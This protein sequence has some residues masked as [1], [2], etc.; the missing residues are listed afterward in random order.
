M[1]SCGPSARRGPPID[2]RSG[3][4][5]C[6]ER[7]LW[8]MDMAGS[9]G[10]KR[11]L[12]GALCV[13][14]VVLSACAVPGP[15]S[16]LMRPADPVVIT[17]G[18]VPAL[19][20]SA[21]GDIV[22]F[23]YLPGAGWGQ[24]PV[25]VDERK[26]VNL[27]TTYNQPAN[28]V[29]IV[30]YADPD[31]FAGADP[32]PMLDADDEIAFMAR[33]TGGRPPSYSVPAGVV[34]GTGVQVLVADP[35][36]RQG[37]SPLLKTG[38]AYLFR[39]SGTLDPAAGRDYVDY[40]FQL[41]SG[42]YKTTY[43]LADGPNPEDS[44]ITTSHYQHH[45][46]DR[47]MSDSI[48]VT[49]P[50]ASGADILDRHK[51][52]FAPG[53]CGRSEDT[54]NDAEGAFI[55]NTNG[56]VRA[57]RSYIGANSGPNTQRDHIFYDQR[58]DI[59]TFL[60]VHAISGVMDFLDYSPD[61]T[62]MT[63]SNDKNPAGVTIDGNPESV[64]PGAPVWEKVD[65]AQGSLTSVASFSTNFATPTTIGYYLDDATPTGTGERQC[66]GDA[67]AYGSSGSRITSALPCTDPAMG[68]TNTLTALRTIYFDSPGRSAAEAK[69]ASERVATPLTTTTSAWVSP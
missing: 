48:T 38:V 61:A 11:A 21:P 54:F 27:G 64:A 46:G 2:T 69:L 33:D 57:I 6:S 47:W 45:F 55:V 67:F 62:G 1:S 4:V 12:L 18:A 7:V 19:I 3:R 24:I 9:N 52:L 25:Q 43:Q 5:P 15:T 39:R 29:N 60:R 49:A 20:G 32:D 26:V 8:G 51:N 13:G 17:G 37:D 10:R 40:R 66:T 63:Y 31:T 68:C 28:A 30:G 23:A 41:A 53:N 59:R 42:D 14:A 35:L 65:G 50:G 36:E 44:T 22:A 34:A 56:P 58:E 16:T